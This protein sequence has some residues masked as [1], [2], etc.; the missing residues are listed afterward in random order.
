MALLFVS[1]RR[2]APYV[3]KS[4]GKKEL[5]CADFPAA[6]FEGGPVTFAA[7]LLK[8]CLRRTVQNGRQPTETAVLRCRHW[9]STKLQ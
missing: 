7:K 1:L 2:G 6:K 3:A 4:S 5:F 9:Q 8:V